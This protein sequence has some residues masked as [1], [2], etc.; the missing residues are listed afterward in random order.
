MNC[1]SESYPNNDKVGSLEFCKQFVS[2]FLCLLLE[3]MFFSTNK[4][5][6]VFD[7][8]QLKGMNLHYFFIHLTWR[9]L[10]PN[11]FVVCSTSSINRMTVLIS[12]SFY[13]MEDQIPFIYSYF[14]CRT[15]YEFMNLF[16]LWIYVSSIGQSVM[17]AARPRAILPPMQ[18]GLA[19]EVHRQFGT[20]FLVDVLNKFGFCSS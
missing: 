14:T 16:T 7:L 15:F 9:V 20:R 6:K 11:A 12:I 17:Q 13:R 2:T 19:L 1:C 8:I 10:R 3:N 5:L 4:D 18:L